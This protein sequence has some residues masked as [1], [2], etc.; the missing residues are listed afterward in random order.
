MRKTN[1]FASV[2]FGCIQLIDFMNILG[3]AT[4]LDSFLEV[5]KT[6]DTK[7][8]FPLWIVRS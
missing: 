1:Q 3:G 6:N 8:F 2:K 4:S 7:Q 5:Y